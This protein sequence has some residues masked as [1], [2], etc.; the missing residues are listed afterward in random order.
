M[1]KIVKLT[2]ISA[3]LLSMA[4]VGCG[5]KSSKKETEDGIV[6]GPYYSVV[7]KNGAK[8]K[9]PKNPSGP[10]YAEF[11]TFL[12]WS[13]YEIVESESQLWDFDNDLVEIDDDTIE[14][15]TVNFYT[16]FN[17]FKYVFEADVFNLFGVWKAQGD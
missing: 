16:D 2:L 9:K 5:K 1:K 11:G 12:G 15:V 7:V 6:F 10:L 14:K 17:T 4:L 8:V 3:G 13:R